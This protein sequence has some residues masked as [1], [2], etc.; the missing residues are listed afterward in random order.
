MT[1]IV[2]S[3]LLTAFP[4]DVS[5]HD[6]IAYSKKT[7]GLVSPVKMIEKIPQVKLHNY[8]F[9][10]KGDL[11]FNDETIDWGLT[12]PTFSNGAAYADFDNDGAI[13][14]VINNI[15]DQA[16]L[17]R[18]TA[19]DKDTSATHFLQIKFKG[20]KQNING[21][22][23][24]ANIYYDHDKQ[25]VYENNPY[26]GYLSTVQCLAHFG[27]GKIAS[28]DSVIIKW[29]NGKQQT[30]KNV[31]A[32][33]VLNVNIADAKDDYSLQKP[34]IATNALFKEVTKESGINYVHSDIELID[35]DLQSLLPHKL[36]EYCPAIAVADV[37][38][39]GFDDL[40]IGGSRSRHAQL[41][42]QQANGK[43][44]QKD[45]Q[46]NVNNDPN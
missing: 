40:V 46:P 35:F 26:R 38:G 11:T 9:K 25:Q 18:N 21:L 30:L 3:L 37:D 6:F 19:R 27:L 8:A 13:D 29:G 10:N 1:A 14:M 28:I 31:K 36:S 22:G 23:A 20:N 39:N 12:V 24:F 17:Y 7:T 32:N 2:I 34:A 33:Q 43:F 5:D 45:L 15:D 41:L 16:L 44:L 4:R 42:L